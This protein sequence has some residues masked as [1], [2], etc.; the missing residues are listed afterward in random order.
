MGGLLKTG[1]LPQGYSPSA[2]SC[3][4]LMDDF[5][6]IPHLHFLYVGEETLYMFAR[7]RGIQ[8]SIIP[9]IVTYLVEALDLTAHRHK[10]TRRYR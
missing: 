8:E 4:V 9:S 5:Y 10:Q 3:P 6:V 1:Y 2:G 7:I